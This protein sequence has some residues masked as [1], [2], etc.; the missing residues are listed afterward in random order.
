MND[1][2]TV[3]RDSFL[4]QACLSLGAASFVLL[5][6][7]GHPLAGATAA[8]FALLGLYFFIDYLRV[9]HR[10]SQRDEP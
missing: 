2:N 10:L 9:G 5:L 7:T 1:R 8:G 3:A 4:S 6:F